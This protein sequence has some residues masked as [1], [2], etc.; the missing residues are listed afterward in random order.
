M[1]YAGNFG[2]PLGLAGAFADQQHS[3]LQ[4]LGGLGQGILAGSLFAAQSARGGLYSSSGEK[5]KPKPKTYKDEL[6][7]ETDEWLE[8]IK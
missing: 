8:D 4:A 1:A 5:V 3:Q 7:A 6:Q 2:N